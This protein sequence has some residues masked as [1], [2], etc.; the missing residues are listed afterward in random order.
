MRS[1]KDGSCPYY[2]TKPVVHCELNF[3][4]LKYC[5]GNPHECK[6]GRYKYS[7]GSKEK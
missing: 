4:W 2:D 7:A 1:K 3:L 6:K 5:K